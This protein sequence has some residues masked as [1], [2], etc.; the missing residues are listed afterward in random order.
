MPHN[1]SAQLEMLLCLGLLSFHSLCI[2]IDCYTML[3]YDYKHCIMLAVTRHTIHAIDS[4]GTVLYSRE[5]II[6]AVYC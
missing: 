4:I 2:F 6:Y 1:R 3:A 5:N